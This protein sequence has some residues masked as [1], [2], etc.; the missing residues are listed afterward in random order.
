[1]AATSQLPTDYA[2]VYR[3]WKS[4]RKGKH[5]SF[6][7]DDFAYNL[8]LNLAQLSCE[9]TSGAYIHGK[10]QPVVLHEK[11][12]RDIAVASVRDRVVHRLIYDYLALIYDKSFDFYVWSGRKGKGLH[13]CLNRTQKLIQRY[14]DGYVWRADIMKLYDNVDHFALR[15]FV[16]SKV[17]R[18]QN[19]MYIID[20]IIDSYQHLEA[21]QPA[22]VYLLV[23]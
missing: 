10:Y 9:L 14:Y 17:Y 12:R 11:K 13:S 7:I 23:I 21:S 16:F 2:S 6:S 3:A 4:F 1:M 5:T 8:E 18:D 15:S 20:K 22:T 19:A